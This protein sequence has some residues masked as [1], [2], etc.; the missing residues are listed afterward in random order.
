VKQV[1]QDLR[2]HRVYRAKLVVKVRKA[3]RV[4]REKPDHRALRVLKVNKALLVLLITHCLL[5]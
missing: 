2:D 5:Q 1:P 3:N 4:Y